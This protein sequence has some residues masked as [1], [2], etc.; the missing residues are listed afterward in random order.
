MFY[1]YGEDMVLHLLNLLK[2]H[3]V[4]AINDKS[5]NDLLGSES[6][7]I[8]KLLIRLIDL[9]L[10]Q[11]MHEVSNSLCLEFSYLL[12]LEKIL[13]QFCIIYDV[14]SLNLTL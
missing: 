11:N 5:V 8:R 7:E 6:K 9:P 2:C 1:S 14:K 4:L 3:M 12:N 10:S 13:D